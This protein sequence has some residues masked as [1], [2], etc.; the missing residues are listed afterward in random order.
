M[1]AHCWLWS[2]CFPLCS[3]KYS[4]LVSYRFRV[5]ELSAGL[6]RAP[7]IRSGTANRMTI[8]KTPV[9]VSAR[10]LAVSLDPGHGDAPDNVAL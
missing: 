4:L 10:A 3:R 5:P 8:R 6:W 7:F 9:T 1:V 2:R